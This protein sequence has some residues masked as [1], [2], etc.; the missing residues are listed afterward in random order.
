M[1]TEETIELD[2]ITL[3]KKFKNGEHQFN[4]LHAKE[5]YLLH[6]KTEEIIKNEDGTVNKS[7]YSSVVVLPL[8]IDINNY[9]AV[10]ESEEEINE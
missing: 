6:D 4:E 9:E 2:N 8:S 1:W 10:L 7:N 5:G 3:L